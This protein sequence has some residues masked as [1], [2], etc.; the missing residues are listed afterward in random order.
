MIISSNFTNSINGDRHR[1]RESHRFAQ[2]P[3]TIIVGSTHS[4]TPFLLEFPHGSVAATYLISH[5]HQHEHAST[6]AIECHGPADLCFSQLIAI[7]HDVIII[8]HSY[9]SSSVMRYSRT[10]ALARICSRNLVSLTG[11]CHT[12]IRSLRSTSTHDSKMN[13]KILS[14]LSNALMRVSIM[15]F[16]IADS[17]PAS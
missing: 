17:L 8:P 10:K 7:S 13:A 11:G 1:W 16:F 12:L 14:H 15:I 5:H 2:L 3:L 9:L 6:G 4:V